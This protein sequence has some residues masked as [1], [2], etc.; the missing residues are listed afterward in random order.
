M[1]PR[2]RT[3]LMVQPIV[4]RSSLGVGGMNP[5]LAGFQKEVD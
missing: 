4:R 3:G 5:Y 1:G 2:D